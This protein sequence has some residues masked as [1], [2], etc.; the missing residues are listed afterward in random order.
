M[1]QTNVNGFWAAGE[2]KGCC[3]YALD[4]AA[5]GGAGPQKQSSAVDPCKQLYRLLDGSK[6]I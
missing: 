5:A 4:S 3:S 6:E 2:V 1:Q